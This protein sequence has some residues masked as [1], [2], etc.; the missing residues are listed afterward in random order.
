MAAIGGRFNR[1]SAE[2]P[3]YLVPDSA[4]PPNRAIDPQAESPKR[5]VAIMGNTGQ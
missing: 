4:E 1:V 3:Q 2:I 5:M